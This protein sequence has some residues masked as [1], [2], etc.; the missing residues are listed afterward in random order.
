MKHKFLQEDDS[1]FDV[2]GNEIYANFAPWLAGLE[3]S[4]SGTLSESTFFNQGKHNPTS[5]QS[6]AGSTV[7]VSTGGITINLVFDAAAMAAPSSFRAGI[8]QAATL[9]A[10]T[11][12]D[13]ITVNLAIDYSGTGGGAA[14]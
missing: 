3:G 9:L 13:K 12:T 7:A 2:K 6:L 4:S 10:Q 11:I 14:A 8:V 5:V 1:A